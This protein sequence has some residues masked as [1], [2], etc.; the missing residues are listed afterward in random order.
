MSS[1]IIP[2]KGRADSRN[3]AEFWPQRLFPLELRRRSSG[4]EPPDLVRRVTA[5]WMIKRREPSIFRWARHAEES[6]RAQHPTGSSWLGR[7][8]AG[9][10]HQRNC[11]EQLFDNRVTPFRCRFL[12]KINGTSSRSRSFTP[13]PLAGAL[14]ALRSGRRAT[15]GIDGQR[16]GRSGAFGAA[17]VLAARRSN[18]REWYCPQARIAGHLTFHPL[19]RFRAD[20]GFLSA[21]SALP[22]SV[23]PL[24][25]TAG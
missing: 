21:R 8:P 11:S 17:R 3:P 12:A 6:R 5:R 4:R 23:T 9:P 7:S 19:V 13:V 15:N 10:P 24:L 18:I 22:N 1:Q 2:L 25:H 16:T 20:C 14:R